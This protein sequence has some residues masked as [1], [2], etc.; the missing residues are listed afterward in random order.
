[1]EWGSNE[2]LLYNKSSSNLTAFILSQSFHGSG[3][4]EMSSSWREVSGKGAAQT[5]LSLHGPPHGLSV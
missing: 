5:P 3:I 1:M 4:Q 2:L